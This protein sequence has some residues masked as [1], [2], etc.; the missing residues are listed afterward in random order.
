MCHWPS[1]LEWYCTCATLN[2]DEKEV[3]CFHNHSWSIYQ[4]KQGLL[5]FYNT[6][7]PE[8]FY[9]DQVFPNRAIEVFFFKLIPQKNKILQRQFCQIQCSPI[10]CHSPYSH[11]L[12]KR[13]YTVLSD[14]CI[15]PKSRK[16]VRDMTG[17]QFT[18]R[19]LTSHHS[20]SKN[21][22]PLGV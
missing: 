7:S 9:N 22:A 19:S 1:P 15:L 16:H 14:V 13:N 3:T 2:R 6:K 4:T 20:H 11:H 12:E 21:S 18:L 17:F 10:A 8:S 5:W